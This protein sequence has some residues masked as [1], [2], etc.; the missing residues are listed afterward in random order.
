MLYVGLHFQQN[1]FFAVFKN[2]AK[3]SKHDMNK[4]LD[5]ELKGDI[6]SCL[7]AIGMYCNIFSIAA[8]F[9]LLTSKDKLVFV[10]ISIAQAFFFL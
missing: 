5:L 10:P 3:Y 8:L 9:S 7:V 6:E 1:Y 2:Y 4:A